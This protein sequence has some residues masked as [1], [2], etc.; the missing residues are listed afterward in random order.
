MT[1][2]H[3]K[4]RTSA[5]ASVVI[6]TY[7]EEATVCTV[8]R[9]VLAQSE[10]QEVIVVDDGSRDL[11]LG[12]ASTHDRRGLSRTCAIR[13]SVQGC[14]PPYRVSQQR[15]PISARNLN[16]TDIEVGHKAFRREVLQKIKLCENRFGFEPEITAK[17][18]RLKSVRIYEVPISYDGRTYAEGKKSVGWTELRR[19]GTS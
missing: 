13:Q 1:D 6:P 14:G 8:V 18:S 4:H 5:C 10:V 2:F 16:L 12:C 17:V 9:R 3:D 19:F 11:D 15:S 7:N